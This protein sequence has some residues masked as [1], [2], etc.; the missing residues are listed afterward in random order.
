RPIDHRGMGLAR[1]ATPAPGRLRRGAR[2]ADRNRPEKRRAAAPR[3]AGLRPALASRARASERSDGKACDRHAAAAADPGERKARG[4]AQAGDRSRGPRCARV[5][6]RVLAAAFGQRRLLPFAEGAVPDLLDTAADARAAADLL[7]WR[8][9]GGA[10]Y[11]QIQG[12][13]DPAS[14]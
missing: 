2:M 9:E 11:W 3:V 13:A 7:G 5:R 6:R 14:A 1:R 10:P 12:G 8:A 4:T